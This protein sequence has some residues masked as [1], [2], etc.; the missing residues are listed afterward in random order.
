MD[1]QRFGRHHRA[2]ADSLRPSS[3]HRSLDTVCWRVLAFASSGDFSRERCSD[4]CWSGI[5]QYQPMGIWNEREMLRI[6]GKV[7]AEYVGLLDQ[8]RI[9]RSL[10]ERSPGPSHV[11]DGG[12][13]AHRSANREHRSSA[14]TVRQSSLGAAML[15]TESGTGTGSMDTCAASR[16]PS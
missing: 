14:D 10:C 15:G 12:G 4:L 2:G 1:V 6:R 13:E 5:L 3:N 11:E 9:R 8:E 7:L 16:S